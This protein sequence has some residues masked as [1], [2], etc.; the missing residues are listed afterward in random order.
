V[1]AAPC[2]PPK[3]VCR[4]RVACKPACPQPVCRPVC[5]PRA[6]RCGVLSKVRDCLASRRRC[7]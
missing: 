5:P 2:C 1:V 7:R 6:P 3:P 4:T